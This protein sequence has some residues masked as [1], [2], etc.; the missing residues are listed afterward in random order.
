MQSNLMLYIYC[1]SVERS[2]G[3]RTDLSGTYFTGTKFSNIQNSSIYICM[4]HIYK[5]HPNVKQLYIYLE[6]FEVSNIS[7]HII[8]SIKF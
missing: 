7:I 3:E 5:S 1:F 8:Y 2:C 6:N 4:F